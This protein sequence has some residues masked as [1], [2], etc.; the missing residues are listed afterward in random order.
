M[1]EFDFKL[2]RMANELKGENDRAAAIVGTSVLETRLEELLTKI[3]ISHKEV[4]NIFKGYAPLSTFSAKIRLSY[5]LGLIP[6]DIYKDLDRIREVRNRF[7]HELNPLSFE[8]QSTADIVKSLNCVQPFIKV[9]RRVNKDD[10][11]EVAESEDTYKMSEHNE[12]PR[13]LW[14]LA[15]SV[16]ATELNALAHSYGKAVSPKNRLDF[17]V[18]LASDTERRA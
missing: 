1:F 11:A 16:L 8:D 5:F 14:N 15:V 7:A 12:E 2:L 9:F 13:N 4:P 6:E 18:K 10:L 3:M 17:E